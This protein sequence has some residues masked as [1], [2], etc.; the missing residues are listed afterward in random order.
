MATTK[1]P[2]ALDKIVR[3]DLGV[4]PV[5]A[6][7]GARQ[8][9]KSTLCQAIAEDRKFTI[10]TL[11]D[12]EYLRKAVEI[13]E[14]LL[15]ELGPKAYIDEAQRAPGIFLAIKTIV[16]RE[17]KPGQYLLSG[18]NQPLML[19]NVGDSLQGRAAYR[20]LRP[21][22]LSELRFDESQRGWSFLFASDEAEILAELEQ[23]A[24]SS[25]VV[26]WRDVVSAGGFPRALAV[27]EDYRSQILNDYI[28]TFANRD[29]REILGVESP[30]RF[31]SFFR[32]VCAW[33]GQV[34]NASAYSRDLGVSVNTIRRW[35]DALKSSYLI[36]I[37]QPYSRN[38]SQ[39]VI[40]APKVYVIDP[41]LSLAGA[42]EVDPNG[43]H[44]EGLV[45]NDLLQWRDENPGRAVF[46]WRQ[47][48]GQEVDFV[49]QENKEIVP[50]EIK[51]ANNI[52][53]SEAKHLV[54]FSQKYPNTRR[55][56]ILSCDSD[57]RFL[58]KNIIAAPWWAVL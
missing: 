43:F 18:S 8:V 34:F 29:I 17:Q 39:R 7:M 46:H 48:G 53:Y 2:R 33:T 12:T 56:L 50:I 47:A 25:G 9:G 54:A 52:G 45:C 27:P 6:V 19:G 40:K 31:E 20:T 10:C 36:E 58:D 22:L 5:V 38:A 55:G 11:D 23:R 44:L 15:D 49:I 24:A 4:Y 32:L 26:D 37:V 1:F 42:N 28:V 13:P 16:D 41:A 14:L 51:A 35:I 30:E 57:I 3:R 21:L